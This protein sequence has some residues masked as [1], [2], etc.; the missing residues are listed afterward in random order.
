MRSV[1]TAPIDRA[2]ARTRA[3]EILSQGR[4]H[5]RRFTPKP[6]HRSWIDRHL[7]SPVAR[8]LRTV[9]RLV[10]SRPGLIVMAM[11][12]VVVTTIA[13]RRQVT[14]RARRARTGSIAVA[15]LVTLDPESLDRDASAAEHRGEYG[16]A[17]QF[18]FRAG[19][20]RL[21]RVGVITLRPD[22]TAGQVGRK[23]RDDRYDHLAQS[24]DGITY[25]D[26]LGTVEEAAVARELWP[27][28]LA[29]PSA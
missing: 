22:T 4:F 3:R 21:D 15:R 6:R 28:V 11:M 8:A 10:F 2:E 18:R 23:L 19:L 1:T 9:G 12:V 25:G 16:L 27:A 26:A 20:V 24:F 29:G 14:R 5:Y 13:G 17:V 7:A